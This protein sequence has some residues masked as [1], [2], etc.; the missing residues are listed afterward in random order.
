[1]SAMGKPSL[2]KQIIKN[3][4]LMPNTAFEQKTLANSVNLVRTKN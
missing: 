4:K 1:M 2:R 3:R